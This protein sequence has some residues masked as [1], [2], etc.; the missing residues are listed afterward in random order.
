[1]P[2]KTNIIKWYKY[3]MKF[4]PSLTHQVYYECVAEKIAE[5]VKSHISERRR[6]LGLN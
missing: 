1:M 5:R 4:R 6:T 3:W 2:A